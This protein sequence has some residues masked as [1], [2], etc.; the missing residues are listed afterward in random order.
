MKKSM[1]NEQEAVPLGMRCWILFLLAIAG[2]T[3]V[4]V[5]SATAQGVPSRV[6]NLQEYRP[7]SRTPV[8]PALK[9]IQLLK[10]AQRQLDREYRTGQPLDA[11]IARF[12]GR[13]ARTASRGFKPIQR[14]TKDDQGGQLGPF[15][16]Q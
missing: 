1:S 13:P 15:Q 5:E 7:I 3:G 2:V 16:S 9:D 12:L 8:P 6:D 4:L 11:E 10:R 14:K